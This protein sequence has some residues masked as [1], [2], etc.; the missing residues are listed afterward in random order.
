MSDEL[1]RL[2]DGLQFADERQGAPYGEAIFSG[3]AD[4]LSYIQEIFESVSGSVDVETSLNRVMDCLHKRFC[5]EAC[6]VLTADGEALLERNMTSFFHELARQVQKEGILDWVARNRQQTVKELGEHTLAVAP[7]DREPHGQDCLVIVFTDIRMTP[8]I[9]EGIGFSAQILSMFYSKKDV[10]REL[11]EK[12][13][14]L[15]MKV[16]EIQELY[17]ELAIVYDFVNEVGSI[18]G[19]QE[20]F[21]KLASMCVRALNADQGFI[22]RPDDGQ[23]RLV[24]EAAVPAANAG[25]R[26]EDSDFPRSFWEAGQVVNS[27][28]AAP[29][30]LQRG[31]RWSAVFSAPIYLDS[32]PYALIVLSERETNK[33]YSESDERVLLSLARQAG[34]CLQSIRMHQ[35]LLDKK[36]LERDLELAGD[37]QRSLLPEASPQIEGLDI[38]YSFQPARKVGGDYFDFYWGDDRKLWFFMGDVSGKGMSA[39]LLMAGLR[40]MLRAELRKAA[41]DTGRL[42]TDLN[43]LLCPDLFEGKFVSFFAGLMDVQRYTLNFSNAGH[44]PLLVHRQRENRVESYPAMDMPLGISDKVTFASDSLRLYPGDALLLYTDGINEAR[45]SRGEEFGLDRLAE[46]F[47]ASQPGTADGTLRSILRGVVAFAGNSGIGDDLAMMVIR[48][49]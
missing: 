9:V 20:L 43:A 48:R 41:K 42:T 31:L 7:V 4:V 19:E 25:M 13:D 46:V 11:L 18:F 24:A 39:A 5:P 23:G 35:E 2:I 38:A 21:A 29:Q 30:S 6:F 26:L 10:S 49:S 28:E 40:S 34:N 22:L 3:D 15:E 12:T 37:I 17:D 8:K 27:R 14:T 45:S 16:A 44:L 32:A 1:D 33:P 36:T 47:Q